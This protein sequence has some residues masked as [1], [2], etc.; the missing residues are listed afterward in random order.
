M[1][2]CAFPELRGAGGGIDDGGGP[3][4]APP[5]R[6]R[7][8]ARSTS[9]RMWPSSRLRAPPFSFP[10]VEQ[11]PAASDRRVGRDRRVARALLGRDSPKPSL[12]VIEDGHAQ[13]FLA[14]RHLCSSPTRSR[15]R[16]PSCDPA[17][18]PAWSRRV[19]PHRRHGRRDIQLFEIGTPFSRHGGVPAVAGAGVDRLPR[20]PITGAA[21]GATRTFSTSRARSRPSRR[22]SRSDPH[23]AGSRRLG[24]PIGVVPGPRGRPATR[25][26]RLSVGLASSKPPFSPTRTKCLRP[27]WV[28][29]GEVDLEFCRR[30]SRPER[31]SLV[32]PPWPRYPSRRA[33]HRAARRR[34][35]VCRQR[36]WHH[37]DCTHRIRWSTWSS[38]NRYQGK[39]I[40]DG[41][42][43]LALRLTFQSAERTLTDEEVQ[44]AMQ[45]II[46]AL[47]RELQAVQR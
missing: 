25:R 19:G 22:S 12:R 2:R 35:L 20:Q 33:R 21:G 27:T 7:V 10:G 9:S 23:L 4:G 11:A 30:P 3:G 26:R 39:G 18:C 1:T 28:W 38:S 14:G 40:P 5:W 45:R 47:T 41:K 34:I 24:P 15:R 46:D 42:V 16:S 13:P 17:W 37:S 31:A 36:S 43:S 8:S 29:V 6:R 44:A 32:V